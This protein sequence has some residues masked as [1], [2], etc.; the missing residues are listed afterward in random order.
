MKFEL[1]AANFLNWAAT[2]D[3]PPFHALLSD[4]PYNLESIAKRFGKPGSIPAKDVSFNRASRGFLGHS[5]DTAIAYDPATWELVTRLLHP[6]AFCLS[7][8]H[9]RTQHRLALALENAGY[10]IGQTIGLFQVPVTLGWTY[11]TG[12]PYG[13]DA[14]IAADRR[15]GAERP[16]KGHDGHAGKGTPVTPLA[17]D[18]E[19]YY[20]TQ[21]LKP[22]LELV[23]VARGPSS[24]IRL[25]SILATGAGA[26][27]IDGSRKGEDHA[28]GNLA[29]VHSLDC[30]GGSCAPDCPVLSFDGPAHYFQRVD[31]AYE[32]AERLAE[33]SPL[34]YV[35][36]PG[37]GERNAGCG[38][39]PLRE[40]RCANPGG[41][42]IQHNP[43]PTLKPVD[44][45]RQLA[46]LLLPPARYAPR[47]ILVP[48]AGVGSEMIGALLA[49]WDEVVGVEVSPEYAQIGQQRLDWAMRAI[50]LGA[51]NVG[52][53]VDAQQGVQLRLGM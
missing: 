13:A 28:F 6:G 52:E 15:A 41:S 19:G 4:W 35:P 42:T 33:A 26:M 12:R 30:T 25:D 44:L 23:I 20:Y 45:C 50:E 39:L 32:I 31:W 37:L 46:V 29:L 21:P 11:G 24:P 5:W 49:G 48:C 51:R 47:R 2:Y 53:I 14:S 8:S 16:D 3:G 22:C 18:W 10:E 43:H 38:D 34:F 36:K 7:F 40:R 1:F 9:P 27:N 17:Q